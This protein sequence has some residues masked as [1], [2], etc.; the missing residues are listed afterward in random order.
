[1][2]T[3]RAIGILLAYL[4]LLVLGAPG[5]D[6][7]PFGYLQSTR[8]QERMEKRHG[9]T[10]AQLAKAAADINRFRFK[11][12][13]TI[14]KVQPIF[15]VAQ[16]WHLYRDGPADIHKLEIHVDGVPV[17]RTLDPKLDWMDPTMRNRRIR[18]VVES[19]VTKPKAS[20]RWGL[21]RFIVE[22]ARADFP[23]IQQVDIIS[24]SGKRPGDRLQQ[25][26]SL[27]AKAPDW[28]LKDKR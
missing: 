19:M 6:F 10:A 17:Y 27:V 28:Q 7:L 22:R 21:G 12:E 3:F 24:L 8:A 2:R 14:G 9:P 1:M 20:N 15:R 26:H 13:D 5:L 25:K 23:K 11:F 16:S 4:F 18:P